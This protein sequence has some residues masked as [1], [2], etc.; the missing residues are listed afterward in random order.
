VSRIDVASRR[1]T[2]WDGWRLATRSGGYAI[3]G[4]RWLA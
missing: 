2:R 3:Y 1:I 4:R